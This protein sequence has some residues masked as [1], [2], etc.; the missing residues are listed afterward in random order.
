MWIPSGVKITN[1][2]I[3]IGIPAEGNSILFCLPLRMSFLLVIWGTTTRS[4]CY[5]WTQYYWVYIT[6]RT[7][8]YT[9]V[10]AVANEN[11]TKIWLP[12]PNFHTYNIFIFFLN[13]WYIYDTEIYFKTPQNPL[14][15]IWTYLN[16]LHFFS[17]DLSALDCIF[18]GQLHT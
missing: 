10:I 4:S 7:L 18:K 11:N 14:L 12:S 16:F 9:T 5:Y 3:L 8:W 6:G 13:I 17:L 1:S 2:G 15:N